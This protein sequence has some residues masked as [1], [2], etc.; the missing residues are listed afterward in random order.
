LR[1]DG[2]GVLEYIFVIFG[3][4]V[5]VIFLELQLLQTV[6]QLVLLGYHVLLLNK[7]VEEGEVILPRRVLQ[8]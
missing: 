7:R 4:K 3:H 6:N 2:V 5:H 8:V 1:P